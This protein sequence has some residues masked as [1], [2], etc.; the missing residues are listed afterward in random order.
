VEGDENME[1]YP[2]FVVTKQKP[3]SM[4]TKRLDM[5]DKVISIS[6]SKIKN[7]ESIKVYDQY[8][9]SNNTSMSSSE[10]S[11]E[12]REDIHSCGF[13]ERTYGESTHSGNTNFTQEPK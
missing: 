1:Q 11:V 7:F 6:R 2:H 9:K 13:C 3:W 4:Q 8:V 5:P 10:D 12:H